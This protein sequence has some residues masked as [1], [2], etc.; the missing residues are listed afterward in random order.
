MYIHSQIRSLPSDKSPLYTTICNC[1]GQTRSSQ[2]SA[3]MTS[4]LRRIAFT[5]TKKVLRF[6]LPVPYFPHVS[7]T[8]A[9]LA[10]I[11]PHTLPSTSSM[12]VLDRDLSKPPFSLPKS[13]PLTSTGTTT[14]ISVKPKLPESSSESGNSFASP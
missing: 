1:R 2:L 6:L 13:P 12:R 4:F 11:D 14:H 7:A 9:A 8:L 10:G 5:I 3:Q